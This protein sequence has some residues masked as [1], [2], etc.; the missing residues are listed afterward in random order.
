MKSKPGR[1]YLFC[2]IVAIAFVTASHAFGQRNRPAID[3]LNRE[4]W[5]PFVNG[6]LKDD[7]RLYV[8]VHSKE[9]HWVRPGSNGRIM[10]HREYAEGSI[11]VMR[12]RKEAGERTEIEFRFLERNVREAFAAEK[13]IFR[14]VLH[15]AGESAV[16]SYGIAHYFSRREDGVWKMLLQ[17]GST[18]KA[19]AEMFEAAATLDAVDAFV[20]AQ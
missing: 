5:R 12:K 10:D 7:P 6:I 1:P 18:E 4:V 19:T 11:A 15:R 9:F 14:F 16:P 3:A 13:V 8:G 2:A 17:Y 20:R